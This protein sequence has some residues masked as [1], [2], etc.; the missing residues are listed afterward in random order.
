[1]D[2]IRI[3]TPDEKPMQA[4]KWL[5][6]QTL[7]EEH[8]MSRLLDDMGD[9]Y[10]FSCGSVYNRHQGQLTKQDFLNYYGRYV[11][12][13]KEG[14]VPETKDYRIPFS[15][16]MTSSL[17]AVYAILVGNDQ[18]IIRIAKPVVQLQAHHLDYSPVDKKF[19]PMILGTQSISWG[20]QFSFPQ[21]FQNG[22][23]NQIEKVL[24]TS[25]NASLF[26]ILQKWVR[27]NTVPTPFLVEGKLHNVPMRLGKECL[28][29]INRHPQLI[30]KGIEVKI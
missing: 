25:S 9:F 1:M 8:E 6:V 29:W 17:D 3:S 5:S 13:L 20:I 19:R 11:Q 22:V 15:S 18:Q 30:A 23:T 2:E 16:A 26:Q 28:S 14:L 24:T 12:Q 10:I 4:S 27:Q 21:L 7:L